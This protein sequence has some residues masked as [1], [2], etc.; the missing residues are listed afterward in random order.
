MLAACPALCYANDCSIHVRLRSSV[1]FSAEKNESEVVMRLVVATLCFATLVIQTANAE[2]EIAMPK[3]PPP[4]FLIL[5][6]VDEK[7]ATFTASAAGG[8]AQHEILQFPDGSTREV[9]VSGYIRI[10][11]WAPRDKISWFDGEGN[12]L[13]STEVWKTVKPGAIVVLSANGKPIDPLYLRLLKKDAYVMIVPAKL[14]PLSTIDVGASSS[15]PVRKV[16]ED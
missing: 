10:S 12:T 8:V 5:M 14:L 1:S 3:G 7:N 6:K 2:N 13:E 4:R 16:S 11:Y 15:I 9:G